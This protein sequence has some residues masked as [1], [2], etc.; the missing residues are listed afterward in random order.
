M[1]QV[2]SAA[3]ACGM[4]KTGEGESSKVADQAGSRKQAA[5]PEVGT[6]REAEKKH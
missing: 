4:H 5:N 3:C 2:V 1:A 6:V